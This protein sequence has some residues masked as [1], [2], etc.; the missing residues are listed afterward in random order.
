MS[1]VRDRAGGRRLAAAAAAGRAVPDLAKA[2]PV[3]FPQAH[4]T[5]RFVFVTH[6]LP[7]PFFVPA[8]NGSE[9][10]SMTAVTT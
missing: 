7:H 3:L 5:W 6:P 1:A 9:A 2:P 4:P 8:K 10:T